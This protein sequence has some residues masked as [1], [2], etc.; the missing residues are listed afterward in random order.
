MQ[1]QNI[2]KKETITY[3]PDK[4]TVNKH[5]PIRDIHIISWLKINQVIFVLAHVTIALNVVK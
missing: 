2:G 4:Y 1:I 3:C 5:H